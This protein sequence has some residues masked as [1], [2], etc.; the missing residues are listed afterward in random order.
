[1]KIQNR[2]YQRSKY[3]DAHKSHVSGS[4]RTHCSKMVDQ[5]LDKLFS[6]K[7]YVKNRNMT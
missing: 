5:V 3:R 1:M 6:N 4:K 2:T 7:R